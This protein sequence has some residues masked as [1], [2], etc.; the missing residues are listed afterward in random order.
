MSLL[1][2]VVFESD[3]RGERSYDIYSRLMKDNII[4]LGT[5]ICDSVANAVVA[6]ILFL[7]QSSKKDIKLYINSPGGSISA[8]LAI[9]DVMNYVQPNIVTT[10]I[11]Q[12]ASMAALILASGTPGRRYAL[13]NAEVLIHQPHG[14]IGGQ[15][16]DIDLYARNILKVRA[17]LNNILAQT[18][19]QGLAKIQNDVERDY[20]MNADEALTYGLIDKIVQPRSKSESNE[21]DDD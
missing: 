6:Q 17:R 7:A 16:T 10:V 14:G 20:I 5:A 19:L 21:E 11:G 9:I 3:S 8:G 12:A 15:A 18:T 1:V 4:F 13:P 2:P